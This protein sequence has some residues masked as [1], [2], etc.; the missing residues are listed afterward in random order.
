MITFPSLVTL[1]FQVITAVL[2]QGQVTKFSGATN[3]R[4]TQRKNLQAKWPTKSGPTLR[5]H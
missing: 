5:Y 3:L 1:E 2:F 4:L